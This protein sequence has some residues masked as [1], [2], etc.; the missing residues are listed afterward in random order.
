M[1]GL[2]YTGANAHMIKTPA[3]ML[4]HVFQNT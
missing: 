2:T 3:T 1:Q 4:K